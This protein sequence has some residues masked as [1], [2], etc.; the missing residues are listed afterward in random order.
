MPTESTFLLAGLFLLLAA[1]GW[2][3][4]RFGER[5]EE[6]NPPP[7]LN[8]DY[9]KGLNF[10]LNE[11]TDQALEHFLK[12]VRVDNKTIETHFALG[13]L[14]RR[15]GEVDRA[16]RIHQ[17]IIA[18]PDIAA[19]QRDQALLSL[20]K[21]YLK[22]G[23]LDRAENL[24][25]RLAEGSRHQVEA[26]EQ[27]C[28]IY[29]QEHEWQKAIDASQQLE[30]LSGNSLE[31]EI[32]H[33]YCELAEQAA[34]ENDYAAARQFVKKSQSGRPR[35]LRGALTRAEIARDSNDTKTALRLFHRILDEHTYLITEALP[36]LVEIHE[37]EG[38]TREL[39]RGLESMLNRNPEMRTDVAYTAI[40]N[41]IGGIGIID[42]CVEGYMLNEPTLGEFIDL[43]HMQNGGDDR[44]AALNKIRSALS[45][46]AESTPRYQCKECGFSSRKLLWQ[47][48]SCKD[49]ETQRPF[50]RVQFDSLLQRSPDNR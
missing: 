21:D 47:C 28:R 31:L 2:A 24:F 49:W 40:V 27:L 35:T 3:L 30:T 44:A 36:E 1:A 16:I 25:M 37:R 10:L 15:R 46:L 34:A 9:L 45:K 32:N 43:Q 19:E 4:G 26:L 50:G 41:N 6:D 42:K 13:N 20:A 33:Y 29:E 17:N 22:A 12:M 48:P 7:P 8:V 11:Q 18:R 14:F 39:E 38:S 5:D 23:L